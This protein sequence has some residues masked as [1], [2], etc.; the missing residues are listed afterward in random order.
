M[1]QLRLGDTGLHVSRLG[2]GM[3]SYGTDP[4]RAWM[5]DEQA[6]EPIVRRAIPRRRSRRRWRRSTTS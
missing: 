6:A 4:R 5:L 2:L 3:M 1:E